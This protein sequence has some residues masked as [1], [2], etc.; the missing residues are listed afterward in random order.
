MKKLQKGLTKGERF[1]DGGRIFVIDKVNLDGSFL[2]HQ[3]TDGETEEDL[4]KNLQRLKVPEL[5][6]MAKNLELD[7]E[8]KKDELIERIAQ[9]LESPKTEDV[10][11][12]E[13]KN[14]PKDDAT[15]T[16]GETEEDDKTT[17]GNDGNVDEN[18][19]EDEK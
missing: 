1:E 7:D 12:E 11:T 9:A 15:V 5:K 19:N 16:D 6:D 14:T 3:V 4:R 2:A 10:Q 8:G 18:N 13:E 17:E